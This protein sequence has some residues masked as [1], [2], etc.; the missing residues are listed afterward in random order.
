MGY[1]EVKQLEPWL[2]SIYDPMS[3]YCYLAV[4]GEKAL[5]FDTVFGIG[6][7]NE[8][9]KDITDKPVIVVLGHGHIDHA[10]GAY[11]FESVYLHDG[12]LGVFKNHTSKEYRAGTAAGLKEG[13]I[14]APPGFDPDAYRDANPGD[15]ISLKEGEIFDLGGLHAEVVGMAGHT[16]GS[17]GLLFKEKQTLLV[18]DAAN[19]H[20]W[21]FL[22]ESLPISEYI[23]MLDRVYKLDFH[24]FY[25]GHGNEPQHKSMLMKYKKTASEASIEKAVPYDKFPVLKPY[26]YEA[27][28]V[29]IVFS[30]RTLR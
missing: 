17:I 6:D 19:A 27:D 9:I 10:N 21:M 18:S 11:Q 20:I 8:V 7:L 3:V 4:G 13:G 29:G 15:T 22:E 24:T 2:Y 26:L 14:E 30:E 5:L 16:A 28:G 12:D 25:T 1:Y 23:K